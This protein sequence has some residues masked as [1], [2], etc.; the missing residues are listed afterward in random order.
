MP[1]DFS[2]PLFQRIADFPALRELNERAEHFSRLANGLEALL[3]DAVRLNV[4]F[5]CVREQKLHFLAESPAWATKL[6][7]LST[8]LITAARAHGHS[9]VLALAVKVR[10]AGQT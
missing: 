5:S 8:T 1:Q 4:R 6:R 9:D 10:R 3:P 2:V 7:L